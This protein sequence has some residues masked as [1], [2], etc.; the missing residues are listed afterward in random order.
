MTVF[1]LY[2]ITTI[3]PNV[4]FLLGMIWYLGLFF[5]TLKNVA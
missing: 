1:E 5:I 3:I 4:E 2:I